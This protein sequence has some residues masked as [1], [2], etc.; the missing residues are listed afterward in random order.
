MIRKESVHIQERYLF[1]SVLSAGSLSGAH[2]SGTGESTTQKSI[3][4]EFD[5]QYSPP[6]TVW[7]GGTSVVMWHVNPTTY[8]LLPG[9]GGHPSVQLWSKAWTVPNAQNQG[10]HLSFWL[11][12]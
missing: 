9:S 11:G 3:K 10:L 4:Q 6:W 12:A 1:V 5:R 2:Y 8:L 7:W